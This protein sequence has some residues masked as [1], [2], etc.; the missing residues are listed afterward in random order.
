MSTQNIVVAGSYAYLARYGGMTVLDITTPSDPQL[1]SNY[2]TMSNAYDIQVIGGLAYLADEESGLR[3]INTV[4]P[5]NPQELGFY[6]TLGDLRQIV[7]TE[8]LLYLVNSGTAWAE[9]WI[10]DISV[11]QNPQRIGY[12][13]IPAGDKGMTV[14]G[15]YAYFPVANGATGF[16][17][18]VLILN[19]ENPYLPVEAGLLTIDTTN[20]I[21]D[22]VVVGH[23][24]YVL[25]YHNGIRIFNI[26][27]PADPVYHGFYSMDNSPSLYNITVS[28]N[29]AYVADG[30]SGNGLR[31][32]DISD[33]A[34]PWQVYTLILTR[35]YSSAAAISGD[36]AY[37]KNGDYFSVVDVTN[38]TTP[39][40]LTHTHQYWMPAASELFGY[41]VCDGC[42]STGSTLILFEGS[43]EIASLDFRFHGTR[44]IAAE[45]TRVYMAGIDGL[46]IVQIGVFLRF[47]TLLLRQVI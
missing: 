37:V 28:G 39:V 12:R 26:S 44:G 17:Q 24:L 2:T 4:N 42:R 38:P 27:D 5:E 13:Q 33:P 11:P 45:G 46:F 15:N 43:T 36:Y 16:I 32:L 21:S 8:N 9:F 23:Y 31:I 41:A 40:A 7:A 10:M 22:L 19:V 25:E 18:D 20:S 3:L 30:Q 1:I 35:N 14:S 6:S 34:V 29:Y 47:L